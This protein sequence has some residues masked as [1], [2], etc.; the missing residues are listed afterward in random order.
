MGQM[1]LEQQRHFLDFAEEGQST[2]NKHGIHAHIIGNTSLIGS[3]NPYGGRWKHPNEIGLDEIPI[4]AQIIER[5]DMLIIFRETHPDRQ[6]DREYVNAINKIRKNNK[7]GSFSGYDEFLKKYLMYARTFNP[8]GEISEDALNMI[9]E[10]WIEMSQRGV[11]GR[12]RKL[13][14]LKRIS[15][16]ISKIKLKNEVDVEDVTEMMAIYNVILM[17]F[18]QI[19]PASQKPS[20]LAYETCIDILREM[21]SYSIS[22]TELIRSASDRKPQIESYIGDN[23]NLRDNWKLRAISDRLSNNPHVGK[24]NE[25]P[26]VFEWKLRDEQTTTATDNGPGRRRWTTQ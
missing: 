25:R 15:V 8:D 13:E 6:K 24:V 22:F 23:F 18:N 10:Y 1:P 14:A 7:I 3:A 16:A 11:L 12:Y 20:E 21:S 4:L 2:N 19:G 26:L 17:H 5:T 9:D